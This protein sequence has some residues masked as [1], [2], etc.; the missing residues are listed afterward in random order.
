MQLAVLGKLSSKLTSDCQNRM[1]ASLCKIES[2][3]P[4]PIPIRSSIVIAA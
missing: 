2:H 1:R 3:C 4:Q